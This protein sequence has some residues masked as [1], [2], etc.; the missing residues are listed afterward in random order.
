MDKARYYAL[1]AEISKLSFE[2]NCVELL[3]EK[4]LELARIACPFRVGEEI[5]LQKPV[6]GST[7]AIITAIAAPSWFLSHNEYA[8]HIVPLKKSGERMRFEMTDTSITSERIFGRLSRGDFA[9]LHGK[10]PVDAL[11]VGNTQGG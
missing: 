6:R 9:R 4:R 8:F 3:S 11:T 10:E 1:K 5:H 7:R 2:K